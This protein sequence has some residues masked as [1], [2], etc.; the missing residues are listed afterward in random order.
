M[1]AEDR[2]KLRESQKEIDAR[3]RKDLRS[4]VTVCPRTYSHKDRG[5][6][7]NYPSSCDVCIRYSEYKEQEGRN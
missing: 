1:S 5:V 4:V 3:N 7:V 2:A 6:C